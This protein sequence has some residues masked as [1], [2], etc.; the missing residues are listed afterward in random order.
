[1]PTKANK[2][3]RGRTSQRTRRRWPLLLTLLLVCGCP[4][5]RRNLIF[6]LFGHQEEVARFDLR[7]RVVGQHIGRANVG[8]VRVARIALLRIG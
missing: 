2:K 7:R 6:E 5:T 3:L 4:E 8:A 1:M